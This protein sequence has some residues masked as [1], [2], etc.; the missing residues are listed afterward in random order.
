[1][2]VL[3]RQALVLSAL[4]AVTAL[5]AGCGQ[6]ASSS[7]NISS[8]TAPSPQSAA[9]AHSKSVASFS[10]QAAA[11]NLPKLGNYAFT[12]HETISQA[13]G[14]NI[15][16]AMT[17]QGRYYNPTDYEITMIYPGGKILRE[18][19]ISGNAY[20][21]LGNAW[22]S[23]PPTSGA[24]TGSGNFS[25]MFTQA[26]S[27]LLAHHSVTSTGTCTDAGRLGHGLLLQ[28]PGIHFQVCVDSATGAVLSLQ[29]TISSTASAQE[30]FQVTQVGG[31]Q[32]IHVPPVQALP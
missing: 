8:A 17:F 20:L 9:T 11:A 30:S 26:L 3:G 32:P 24:K 19:F 18:R 14:V 29:D 4:L 28:D 22:I 16:Q 7:A 15:N 13:A 23:S 6:G 27:N 1:M 25:E 31:I 5:L 2:I 10:G 12:L 21:N